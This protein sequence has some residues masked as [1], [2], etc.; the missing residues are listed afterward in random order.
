MAG[1]YSTYPDEEGLVE[2][3]EVE[4]PSDQMLVSKWLAALG[5]VAE[6]ASWKKYIRLVAGDTESR[7]NATHN[8]LPLCTCTGVAK[9]RFEFDKYS[10]PSF[11]SIMVGDYVLIE[12][13]IT[14]AAL[15]MFEQRGENTE[16]TLDYDVPFMP[17]TWVR[18]DYYKGRKKHSA[19]ATVTLT[20]LAS[21]TQHLYANVQRNGHGRPTP[22]V[23]D[24][25]PQNNNF[26]A[27]DTGFRIWAKG[28]SYAGNLKVTPHIPSLKFTMKCRVTAVYLQEPL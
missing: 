8:G 9:N 12:V 27:G 6:G 24:C 20:G 11:S 3:I 21:G 1:R 18:I 26:V 25:H 19:G 7:V 28:R 16:G 22:C 5:C 23:Y 2:A 13:N 10:A 4:L 14:D 17:G 15:P